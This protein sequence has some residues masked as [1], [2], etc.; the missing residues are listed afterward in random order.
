MSQFLLSKKARH[1]LKEIAKY[2]YT[3]WGEDQCSRYIRE[4]DEVLDK[5]AT[6]ALQGQDCDFR[7]GYK[8]YYVGKHVIFFH[9]FLEKTI[10]IVRILHQSMDQELHI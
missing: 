7:K 6:G 9:Q 10:K 5:L 3:T 8:K 2:T 4:V 1:D